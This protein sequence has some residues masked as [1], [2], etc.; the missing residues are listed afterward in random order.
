MSPKAFEAD[1]KG[2]LRKYQTAGLDQK[3]AEEQHGTEPGQ[4]ASVAA[5][6]HL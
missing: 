1:H 3:Q 4:Y 6:V 5:V 2:P